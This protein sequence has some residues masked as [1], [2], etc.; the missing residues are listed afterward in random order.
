MGI[1]S[2]F[3]I[4]SIGISEFGA[5]RRKQFQLHLSQLSQKTIEMINDYLKEA[6]AQ[7]IKDKL[8]YF[9][10]YLLSNNLEFPVFDLF[11]MD[12]SLLVSIT[13]SVTTYLVILLQFQPPSSVKSI[14]NNT[15][16]ST[17][18]S[19]INNSNVII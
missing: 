15:F 7:I 11:S 18:S 17:A 14:A 10:I 12:G 3:V 6:E 13:G 2:F 4:S 9:S 8:L 1:P 19:L 5:K 16:N